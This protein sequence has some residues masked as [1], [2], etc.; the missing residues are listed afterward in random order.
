MGNTKNILFVR[1]I[2][3]LFKKKQLYMDHLVFGIS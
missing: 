2:D 1:F 3:I